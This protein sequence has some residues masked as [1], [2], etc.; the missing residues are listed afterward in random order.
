MVF[1]V[2]LAASLS[3]PRRRSTRAVSRF[4]LSSSRRLS[5]LAEVVVGLTLDLVCE[6]LHEVRAAQRVY[7]ARHPGFEGGYLLGPDSY[8]DG[9][10]RGQRQGLIQRV[11]VQALGPAEDGRERLEGRP[12]HVVVRL[13]G[14]EG[15]ACGLGVEAHAQG[16]LVSGAVFLLHHRGPDAPG[17]A[18][19]GDLLEEVYVRV[20]EERESRGEAVYREAGL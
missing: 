18:E 9:L 4:S 20:E 11:G 12:R 10:L 6:R 16:P 1:S 13:L 14:R 8:A 2:P 17:G 3:S 7:G 5:C 15:D 19:L